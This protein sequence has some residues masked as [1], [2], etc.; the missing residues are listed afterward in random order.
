MA[1]VKPMPGE[2]LI[3]FAWRCSVDIGYWWPD[4]QRL[5]LGASFRSCR[6]AERHFFEWQRIALTLGV[7]DEELFEM[8]ERS[9]Y[10]TDD[11]ARRLSK[12]RLRAFPWL[13]QQ[14]Y[15]LYS[16]ATL[17]RGDYLR[18]DWL[19]PDLVVDKENGMLFVHHCHH[20]GKRL[21][22]L[23]WSHA[24]PYCPAKGCDTPLVN[25]PMI[26]ASVR[27]QEL[28]AAGTDKYDEVFRRPID[29]HSMQL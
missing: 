12:N 15:P 3:A 2:S 8:S 26:K 24:G 18:I 29:P 6:L 4:Y 13:S 23:R 20:C 22:T 19:R 10:T 27:M 16:P 25:G 9:F 17:E 5:A 1:D 7:P 14:G 21:A 28:A 11:D